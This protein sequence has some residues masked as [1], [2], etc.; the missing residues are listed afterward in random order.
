MAVYKS[1]SLQIDYIRD[2]KNAGNVD[3]PTQ[4]NIL[5]Y[6]QRYK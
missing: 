4:I 2:V 5:N 6:R 3:S 1:L